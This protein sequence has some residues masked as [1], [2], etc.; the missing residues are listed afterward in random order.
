[1]SKTKSD[2]A[3]YQDATK[4]PET[5]PLPVDEYT[6]LGGSY[7]I[8]KDGKRRPVDAPAAEPEPAKK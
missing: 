6:G 5:D 4:V 3:S 8:G 1:M 2:P 7:V